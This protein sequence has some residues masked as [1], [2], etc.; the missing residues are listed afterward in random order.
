M[1]THVVCYQLKEATQAHKEEARALWMS[2]GDKIPCIRS[3]RVGEDVRRSERSYDLVL[4]M[5]FD[6]LDDLAAY[7]AHPDHQPVRARIHELVAR[8]VSVDFEEA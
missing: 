7:Q 1:L 2:L 5:T 3:V 4:I 6:S 8:S